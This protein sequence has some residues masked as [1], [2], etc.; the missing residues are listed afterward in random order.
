MGNIRQLKKDINK[1][2]YC[3]LSECFAI[4]HYN[5]N[6]EE[7][8]FDK[9]IKKVVYLRNDLIVRANHPELDAEADTVKEHYQAVHRDLVGLI[10]VVEKF[11]KDQG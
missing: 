10:D 11:K 3:L 6:L 8:E 7:D 1:L 4:K 5:K 2:A 9:I